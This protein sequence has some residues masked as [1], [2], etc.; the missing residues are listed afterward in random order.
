MSAKQSTENSPSQNE[1]TKMQ[2]AVESSLKK[3]NG[4]NLEMPPQKIAPSEMMGLKEMNVEWVAVIPYAFSRPGETFVRFGGANQWWSESTEGTIECITM[5]HAGNMKVMLKP[6]IWVGDGHGW[7]GDFNF[8]S[9]EK[10]TAWEEE[11]SRYILTYAEIAEE[12]DVELICIGTEARKSAVKRPQFWIQLIKDVRSVYNGK[13]TYAANWDNYMKIDFWNE[14]DYIGIDSYFP[15]SSEATPSKRELISGWNQLTPKLKNLSEENE[16]PILFTE[17]GYKS[18]EYTNS[19]HWNYKEDTVRTN[20]ITQKT[21][22]EALFESI[23]QE[24]FIAGGFFW[25]YH[26][27]QMLASK[28]LDRRYTPQGKEAELVISEWYGNK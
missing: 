8:D 16:L 4:A 13:V 3:I 17:Y 28:S 19:G 20:N 24:D 25:K 11:F 12:H 21:A 14:L 26:F 1:K 5:A 9:D 27:K 22:Y 10:W 23:W 7:L 18:I 2:D 15:L 6:H